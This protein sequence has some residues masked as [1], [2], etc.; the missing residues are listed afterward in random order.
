MKKSE[1]FNV[2]K[3]CIL[4]G[5]CLLVVAVI[6]PVLWQLCIHSYSVK[7]A[8]YVNSIKSRIPEPEGAVLEERRDNSMP[9]LSVDNVDFAGIIEMSGYDASFPVCDDWGSVTEFPCRFSGSIYDRSIIIGAT[10]QKGQFDFYRDISVGDDLSFTD[11]EGNCFSYAVK[12]LRYEKN[13]DRDA[14]T[15]ED[16]DLTLFI[17]NTYGFEYLIVFCDAAG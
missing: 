5:V 3:I 6:V 11:M 15:R 7:S 16:A 10:S 12:S 13:A 17:K 9:V 2:R 8:S 14:M 4:I 1:K